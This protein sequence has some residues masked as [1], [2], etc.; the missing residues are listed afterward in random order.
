MSAIL[1]NTTI[2]LSLVAM[3][4]AFL[5]KSNSVNPENTKY[6]VLA[7]FILIFPI[8][9][10][11]IIPLEQELKEKGSGFFERRFLGSMIVLKDL[12]RSTPLSY[13]VFSTSTGIIS[14]VFIAEVFPV[15]WK[16]GTPFEYEHAIGFS[17]CAAFFNAFAI[18]WYAKK[19]Q[20]EG[21]AK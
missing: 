19:A 11:V 10:G 4:I 6:F 16:S 12:V 8:W 18:L 9:L 3:A 21:D 15:Y 17:S 13:S 1:R 7:I 14:I 5:V 20:M 2:F